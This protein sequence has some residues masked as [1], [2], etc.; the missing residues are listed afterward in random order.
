M[1]NEF[2]FSQFGKGI[3]FHCPSAPSEDIHLGGLW[4]GTPLFT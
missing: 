3:L 1:V 2:Y 4:I